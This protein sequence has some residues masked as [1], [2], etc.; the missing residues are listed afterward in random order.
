MNPSIPMFAKD[1]VVLERN[2]GVAENFHMSQVDGAEKKK[3]RSALNV[4]SAGQERYRLT[5]MEE[6]RRFHVLGDLTR[7]CF[8]EI[9]GPTELRRRF[10]S[11]RELAMSSRPAERKRRKTSGRITQ[12][13][14]TFEDLYGVETN[15]TSFSR[16]SRSRRMQDGKSLLDTLFPL[17]L[18]FEKSPADSIFSKIETARDN[19]VS[20][21]KLDNAESEEPMLNLESFQYGRTM[22]ESPHG[23]QQTTTI[24]L[25][26]C[27]TTS[28]SRESFNR[29]TNNY[30]F[31]ETFASK[32]AK[33]NTTAR[34]MESSNGDFTSMDQSESN[35]ESLR[36]LK[37]KQNTSSVPGSLSLQ[38]FAPAKS[39]N[40]N[41]V[42]VTHSED[43]LVDKSVTANNDIFRLPSQDDNND[44]FR[45]PSQ[46]HDD[47]SADGSQ[48]SVSHDEKMQISE[49]DIRRD[50]IDD[51]KHAL[52]S[53]ETDN[54]GK[55]CFRL[56][57]P[58]SSSEEESDDEYEMAAREYERASETL[59]SGSLP[60]SMNNSLS[61]GDHCQSSLDCAKNSQEVD[62]IEEDD[63]SPI[64][65]RG[66]PA[67][68]RNKPV[69]A[70]QDTQD[71]PSGP[72]AK[73][74]SETQNHAHT[75]LM[76]SK[77]HEFSSEKT[78]EYSENL[79]IFHTQT[80]MTKVRFSVEPV[81]NMSI[82]EIVDSVALPR[83]KAA[84]VKNKRI[85]AIEDTPNSHGESLLNAVSSNSDTTMESNKFFEDLKNTQDT[86]FSSDCESIVCAICFG[87][88]S[89]DFDPIILCD[90]FGNKTCN[91]AVH[92]TCYN[93]NVD[94]SDEN[95]IWR[96]DVCEYLQEG[97]TRSDM[98]CCLCFGI[99]GVLKRST[100]NVWQHPRCDAKDKKPTRLHKLT[101]LDTYAPRSKKKEDNAPANYS[102]RRPL[103][104]L[105]TNIDAVQ[106]NDALAPLDADAEIRKK[107]RKEFYQKF[108]DDEAEAS[109]DDEIDEQEEKEIKAIEEDEAELAEGFINDS[110]QLGYTQDE[111]DIDPLDD[112]VTHRALDNERERMR[113][114]STP[115]MNRLMMR[116]SDTPASA[117]DSDKGLGRMHFIRSVLEHHRRGGRAEEI[118]ELYQQLEKDVENDATSVGGIDS[119]DSLR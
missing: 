6:R 49:E 61:N 34:F 98:Q 2:M 68:K 33:E 118:E 8:E 39:T 21:V 45:L 27:G 116:Q 54:A 18:S 48:V 76:T 66:R 47:S 108:I 64:L 1:P 72:L 4:T 55:D 44:I 90:G 91:F 24:S 87:K 111:L 56:P 31:R 29:T 89:P 58:S 20:D 93:A 75:N 107:R 100:G 40:L 80:S 41:P 78:V 23:L 60:K 105:S 35:V 113:Q 9:T 115:M 85:F 114:F 95:S 81:D 65:A 51:G 77:V 3:Q 63:I 32:A 96:C 112:G 26:D 37:S 71:S 94:L 28:Q 53:Q 73:N 50:T 101:H 92:V 69:L 84:L 86:S 70:I 99:S 30:S 67:A 22:R 106:E 42:N 74:H 110:S 14:Q 119:W 17:H 16:P 52:A 12:M 83:R 79:S 15:N 117:P 88:Q 97:G 38:P 102:R 57:T 13:L 19:L 25:K 103:T 5:E 10:L 62:S 109:D 82:K 104:H 7:V 59:S 36:F 46:D 11:A 43:P